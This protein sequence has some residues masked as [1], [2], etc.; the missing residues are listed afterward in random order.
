MQAGI[1]PSINPIAAAVGGLPLKPETSKSF[2]AGLVFE[3]PWL[4]LT[5]DY[6]NIKMKD[7]LT[8]SATYTLTDAQRDAL[9]GQGY[10]FASQI[11]SFQFYTN[12]FSS[13]TQGVDVVATVP[14]HLLPSGRTTFS[15]A[16]NYTENKVTSYD[17]N[18]PNELLSAARVIQLEENLPKWRGNATLSHTADNWHA[19]GR[20][21]YYGKY[22]ELH[23]NSL[24]LRID[25]GDEITVDA[26]VGYNILPSLTLSVGATD[27]FN[28]YP[29][30]NPYATILGSKYPTTSPMGLAGGSY[31]L[32]LKK[33]F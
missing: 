12:D 25:A 6:F 21:N 8:Q 1:I 30:L 19:F 33:T 2:S 16:A 7:R 29:D 14:L 15:L 13:T 20:V 26:E 31:Y 4:T 10:A 23:V 11:G 5:V 3:Q 22:T 27:L 17:P 18:D 24:G 9:V 28:N 32:Q